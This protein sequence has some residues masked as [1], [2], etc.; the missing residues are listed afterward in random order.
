MYSNTPVSILDPFL[1]NTALQKRQGHY[2]TTEIWAWFGETAN[3]ARNISVCGG[4][5]ECESVSYMLAYNF[6][7]LMQSNWKYCGRNHFKIYG[8]IIVSQL[9]RVDLSCISHLV[10]T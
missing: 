9:V 4:M 7:N 3:F 8:V 2:N 6:H 10:A 1:K 5:H